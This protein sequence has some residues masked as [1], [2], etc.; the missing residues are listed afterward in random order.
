MRKHRRPSRDAKMVAW[1]GDA[2]E[3]D[4]TTSPGDG[5]GSEQN[6]IRIPT[7]HIRRWPALCSDIGRAAQC[8]GSTQ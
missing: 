4:G 2:E 8:G 7:K 3:L 1:P 6:V 5:I